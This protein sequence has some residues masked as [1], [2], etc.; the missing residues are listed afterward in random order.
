VPGAN[1][2][3]AAYSANFLNQY[4]WRDVPGAADILGIANPTAAVTVNGV[5]ATRQGEY[6][7]RAV[8]VDN[9]S[10]WSFG[11]TGRGAAFAS[12]FGPTPTVAAPRTPTSRW[13]TMAGT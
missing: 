13:G 1:P 10:A 11:T 8:P 12:R 5:N 9:T 6:F 2:R 3:T 4:S 7:W